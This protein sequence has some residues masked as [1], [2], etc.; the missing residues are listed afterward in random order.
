MQRKQ[1]SNKIK[2]Y[3]SEED[4]VFNVDIVSTVPPLIRIQNQVV[5]VVNG[6][7]GVLKCDVEAFPEAVRYWERTDGQILE[8]GPK[9]QMV[10]IEN[11]RYKVSE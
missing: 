2:H 5:G 3:I 8:S 11:D 6:S 1:L 4:Q 9:Y 10:S 7:A